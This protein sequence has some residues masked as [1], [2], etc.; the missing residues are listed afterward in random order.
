MSCW[1]A[2]KLL[3]FSP[4]SPQLNCKWGHLLQ[5]QLVLGSMP[6][7]F[8]V[9]NTPPSCAKSSK[10]CAKFDPF[11]MSK[12]L[13]LGTVSQHHQEQVSH[14]FMCNDKNMLAQPCQTFNS[15]SLSVVYVTISTDWKPSVCSFLL[16]ATSFFF[17][18]LILYFP[19]DFPPY[20]V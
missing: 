1:I 5:T 17:V 7:E 8:G 3:C 13:M 6:T 18:L 10:H 15:K 14:N 9:M 12:F 20:H 2:T 11:L 19:F 4:P 16:V